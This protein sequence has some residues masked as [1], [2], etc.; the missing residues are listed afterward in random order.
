MSVNTVFVCHLGMAFSKL[1]LCTKMTNT[2]IRDIKLR[3]FVVDHLHIVYLQELYLFLLLSTVKCCLFRDL[4][5]DLCMY[6][7]LIKWEQNKICVVTDHTILIFNNYSNLVTTESFQ[8]SS[9]RC[10]HQKVNTTVYQHGKPTPG[11]PSSFTSCQ[12]PVVTLA[13]LARSK[14]WEKKLGTKPWKRE[15]HGGFA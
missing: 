12:S 9:F 15:S 4:C 11:N 1:N 3:I 10:T 7:S 6:G 13:N 5:I 14:A 8:V 2:K